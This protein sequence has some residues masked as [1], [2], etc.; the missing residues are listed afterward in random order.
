MIALFRSTVILFFQFLIVGC[1]STAEL[2]KP[3]IEIVEDKDQLNL[4]ESR[5]WVQGK[6]NYLKS[7]YQERLDPYFGKAET[8]SGCESTSVKLTAEKS[9]KNLVY[10]QYDIQTTSAGAVGVC[11]PALQTHKM[12]LVF[13]ACLDRALQFTLKAICSKSV[14]GPTGSC[15]INDE[16]LENYCAFRKISGNRP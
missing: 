15:K 13:A 8:G 1:Q 6:K 14:T 9:M 10:A 5:A 11:D 2:H 3:V 7:L 16:K 12:T 4:P